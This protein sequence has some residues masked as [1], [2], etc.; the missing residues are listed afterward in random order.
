MPIYSNSHPHRY[1][2]IMTS[3]TLHTL[4]LGLHSKQQYNAFAGNFDWGL[5]S[6][7]LPLLT[8]NEHA[9]EVFV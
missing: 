2:F 6:T 4:H 5:T 8:T 9:Q 3:G 7:P 1:L